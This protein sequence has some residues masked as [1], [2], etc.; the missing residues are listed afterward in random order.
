M[1]TRSEKYQPGLAEKHPGTLE[2][3]LREVRE[4]A[5]REAL[6]RDLK[7]ERRQLG[8]MSDAQLADLGISRF[9]AEA[10]ARRDDIPDARLALL[11]RGR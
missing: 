4:W 6:R 10:E 1:T 3:L 8:R 5:L 7:R 9:E 11:E 2:R